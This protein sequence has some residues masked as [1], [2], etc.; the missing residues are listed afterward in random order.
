[1]VLVIAGSYD[2]RPIRRPFAAGSGGT[3]APVA[4]RTPSDDDLLAAAR[5][6]GRHA[7][8]PYSGWH[9]GAA[10]LFLPP[11]GQGYQG[12]RR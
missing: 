5:A 12:V 7:H 10:A 1:M 6:A 4:Q 8:A 3:E 11:D 9:V 2:E